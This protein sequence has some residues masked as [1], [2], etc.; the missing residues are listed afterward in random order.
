MSMLRSILLE[1]NLF[2]F[3]EARRNLGARRAP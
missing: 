1:H 3:R 2:S